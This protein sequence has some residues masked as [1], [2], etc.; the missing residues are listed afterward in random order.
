MKQEHHVLVKVNGPDRPGITAALTEVIGRSS[1]CLEDIEQVVVQ[2]QLTLCLLLRMTADFNGEPLLKEML[3]VAKMH[4]QN[5]DFEIVNPAKYED[6]LP[7]YVLTM[8]GNP[9]SADSI[10]VAASTLSLHG[11]N[12]DA[13]R[14][15][16]HQ[17]LASLELVVELTRGRESASVL[18]ESLLNNLSQFEVDIAFQRETLTRRSKRLVVMDIDSTLISVEVI[19]E[20]AKLNGTAKEVSSIT[21]SAMAGEL[22]F[23]D[24]LQKR[25]KFLEGIDESELKN[26]ADKL[27][28]TP[29]AEILVMI[30]KKLGYKIAI[31]SGGFTFAA[32]ALKE[33]LGL[34]Y[35]FANTLEIADGKL[36]GKVV[37]EVVNAE[38]KASLLHEIAQREGISPEQ[39]IAI[40]DGSNDAQMLLAA[41]LGIAFHAKKA[42]Q[43]KADTSLS[44]GGLERILYLLGIKSDE[45]NEML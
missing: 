11:A 20:L 29:G 21:E 27:P 16:S 6:R 19:D 45:I 7:H 23:T 5:L 26:L 13:I 37:G 36:T 3:Y 25:V 28:L 8:L 18:K 15:L 2:S 17:N 12:I 32:S 22:E 44:H 1:A 39:T 42:L 14:R 33:K 34:D 24:S 4:G 10:H 40:G 9:I 43:D 31:I 35:A 41:G 30:L 38:K